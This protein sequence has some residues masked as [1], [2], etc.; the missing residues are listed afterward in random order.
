MLRVGSYVVTVA[1]LLGGCSTKGPAAGGGS[2]GGFP[3]KGFAMVAD[4]VKK[5]E[6][7]LDHALLRKAHDAPL[8]AREQMEKTG[9]KI[10]Y[11]KDMTAEETA[12]LD[13]AAK[14]AGFSN[15]REFHKAYS[16]LQDVKDALSAMRK[17]DSGTA[18]EFQKAMAAEFVKTVT[19]SDLRFVAGLK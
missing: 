2:G 13:A 17:L 4:K 15:A 16:A 6:D 14:S 8:A 19:E 11:G 18:S 12:A 7:I 10:R 5:G 1:A 3:E 9:A